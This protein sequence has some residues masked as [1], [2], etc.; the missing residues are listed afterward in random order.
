MSRGH[1]PIAQARSAVILFILYVLLTIA[2]V[3]GAAMLVASCA[4]LIRRKSRAWGVAVITGGLLGALLAAVFFIL[5]DLVIRNGHEPLLGHITA[6][7][8]A[9]GFGFGGMFG[10]VVFLSVRVL[11][12]PNRW[13]DR[14]RL[15]PT[16]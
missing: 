9:A 3:F 14:H 15:G 2:A 1:G 4:L 11:Q 12:S 10:V 13:A 5:F 8:L 16:S 6:R 7:F